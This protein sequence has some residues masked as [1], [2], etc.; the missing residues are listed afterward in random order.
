MRKISKEWFW[1]IPGILL[2]AIAGYIYYYF[3]GCDGTCLITSSPVKSTIY[4]AIMGGLFNSMFK[5]S[6]KE[7][8]TI[9]DHPAEH[10]EP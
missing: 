3:W 1:Y 6:K 10:K 8:K 9:A 7:G 2:G 4:G 5:P